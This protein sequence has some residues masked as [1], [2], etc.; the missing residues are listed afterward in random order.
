VVL[1]R[2]LF[3]HQ[4]VSTVLRVWCSHDWRSRSKECRRGDWSR[5]SNIRKH[6]LQGNR[7]TNR[8]RFWSHS[9]PAARCSRRN[10]STSGQHAKSFIKVKTESV[11]QP[12]ALRSSLHHYCIHSLFTSHVLF[13]AHGLGIYGVKRQS[14]V[15][16][17]AAQAEAIAKSNYGFGTCYHR[18]SN[19]GTNYMSLITCLTSS[20]TPA[21]KRFRNKSAC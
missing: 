3:H 2:R 6:H 14:S 21:S 11:R 9:G 10:Q 17:V 8:P 7:S 4:A 18:Y 1:I 12:R 20:R 13:L 19:K 16:S 15:S 5:L